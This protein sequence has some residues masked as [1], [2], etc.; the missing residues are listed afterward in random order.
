MLTF[1]LRVQKLQWLL[2]Q[3]KTVHTLL[4]FCVTNGMHTSKHLF[5]PKYNGCS[6]ET[7]GYCLS[8]KLD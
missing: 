8:C 2:A 7:M 1:A 3:I 5:I 6:K 4:I